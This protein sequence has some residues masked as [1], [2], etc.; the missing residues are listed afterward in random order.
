ME[1]ATTEELAGAASEG[2]EVE[3]LEMWAETAGLVTIV[4]DG[5]V[6]NVLR[7]SED[8]M[9]GWLFRLSAHEPLRET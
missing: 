1:R 7:R 2:S 3:G 9:L 6:V 5:A 4:L 8:G